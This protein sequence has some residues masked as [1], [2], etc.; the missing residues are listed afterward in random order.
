VSATRPRLLLVVAL[1]AGVLGWAVTSLVDRFAD[2]TLPVPVTVPLL[3][4]LL[5]IALVVWTR[6]TR[7][8]L[9]RRPGTRP[10][11]PLVAARS[12]ALALA[13]S[14]TGA[15]VGGFYL[16]VALTLSSSW[17]I[18]YVRTV[19]VISLVSVVAALGVMLAGLWLERVCRIPPAD[20]PPAAD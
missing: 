8:R 13:A 14:R 12:A 7:A 15:T 20:E 6:G 3:L 9:E 2:R 16:G 17:G 5:A 1:V 4:V 18:D 10:M 11:P 19:I